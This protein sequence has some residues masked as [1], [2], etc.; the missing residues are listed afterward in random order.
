VAKSMV[1]SYLEGS[2]FMAFQHLETPF[3]DVSQN[4]IPAFHSSNFITVTING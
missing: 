3:M 4:C 1:D 2:T